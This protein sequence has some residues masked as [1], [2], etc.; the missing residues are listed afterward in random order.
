MPAHERNRKKTAPRRSWAPLDVAPWVAV[1]AA[2]SVVGGLAVGRLA[3][4]GQSPN[5]SNARAVS[6]GRMVP[7]AALASTSGRRLSL[8]AFRGHFV[9]LFFYE[10]AT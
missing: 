3:S 1:L 4:H 10:G 7:K 5:T 2:A 9:V 8:A 6:L